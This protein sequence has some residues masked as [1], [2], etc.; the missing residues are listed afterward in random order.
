MS[1]GFAALF[2]FG[3]FIEGLF[4]VHFF[5]VQ[6]LWAFIECSVSNDRTKKTRTVWLLMMV[7]LGIVGWSLIFTFWLGAAVTVAY[8]LFAT[9]SRALKKATGI[10]L[11]STLVLSAALIAIVVALPDA[12]DRIPAPIRERIMAGEVDPVTY[13]AIDTV[14]VND[15]IVLQAQV[16]PGDTF[17]AL[18]LTPSGTVALADFTLRGAEKRSAV[19]VSNRI[20]Q[21]AAAPD[22]KTIYALTRHDV[23]TLDPATGKF[24]EL[25]ADTSLPRIS[26]P[27]GCA[28]DA[29]SGLLLFDSRGPLYTFQD[30]RDKWQTIEQDDLEFCAITHAPDREAFYGLVSE[31]TEDY[32]SRIVRMNANGAV[33]EEIVLSQNIPTHSWTNRKTQLSWS[34]ERLVILVAPGTTS[35]ADMRMYVVDPD[36]GDVRKVL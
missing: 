11:V 2:M 25:P 35:G 36:T 6:P 12:R 23:G 10:P 31:I 33:V 13:E 27:I 32:V 22:G 9:R 16:D 7:I 14:A 8:G 5:V 30:D 29:S 15:E 24:T 4:L 21:V 20:Q 18:L 17:K 3:L 19:P 28:Y 34:N 1:D 26:W